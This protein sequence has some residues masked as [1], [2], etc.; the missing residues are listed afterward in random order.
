MQAAFTP[1]A[2]QFAAAQELIDA[3]E[4]HQKTGIGAFSFKGQM[5]DM[6]TVL[7]AKNVMALA[8][9]S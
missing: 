9:R 5:I 2:E 1:T 3:F 4:A 7:Q 8:D 6:P